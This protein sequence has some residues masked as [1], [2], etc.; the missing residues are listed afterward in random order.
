MDVASALNTSLQHSEDIQSRPSE[1]SEVLTRLEEQESNISI[2]SESIDRGT[3][4]THASA[5]TYQQAKSAVYRLCESLS[6]ATAPNFALLNAVQDMLILTNNTLTADQIAG[7]HS[8][9]REALGKLQER[10]Q[11]LQSEIQFLQ[12][13]AYYLKQ[14]N[15]TLPETC[16]SM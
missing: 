14:L 11:E 8:E 15:S 5:N 10:R 16:D 12:Q 7:L 9:L 1:A 13:E 2:V 3:N 4:R 6:T